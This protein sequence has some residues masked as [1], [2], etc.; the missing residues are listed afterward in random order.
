MLG[1]LPYGCA[2]L[3]SMFLYASHKHTKAAKIATIALIVNMVFSLILM[4]PMGA[5]GLA[6]AGSIGGWTLFILT[7]KE[8][9]FK[10]ILTMINSKMLIYFIPSMVI[11]TLIF[12]RINLWIMAYIH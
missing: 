8:I 6:L 11:F 2:K 10:K 9:G 12:Y 3:F 4:K 1:L 7:I 5:M